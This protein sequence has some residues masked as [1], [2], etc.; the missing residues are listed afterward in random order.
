M[1]ADLC[2]PARKMPDLECGSAYFHTAITFGVLVD[3]HGAE[4]EVSIAQNASQI[5]SRRDEGEI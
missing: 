2:N 1:D 3:K 5:G 4:R